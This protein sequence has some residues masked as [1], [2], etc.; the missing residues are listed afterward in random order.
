VELDLEA[1]ARTEV[2]ELVGVESGQFVLVNDDDLTYCSV[3]LD[4]DSLD[5]VLHR[6][7]EI[8]EPL[9]R[10]LV[11]SAAWE[12]TRPAEPRARDFVALVQRGIETESEIGVVQRLLMQAH[13]AIGSYAD[14]AWATETGW[15]AFADRLLELARAAEAGSDRQLAFVNALTGARLESRHT[16][17]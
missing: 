4:P 15:P 10:T 6:I 14:P 1:A 7:H 3:R 16:D 9:P 2:P 12:M 8:V 11:W 5:V 17:V 13:T